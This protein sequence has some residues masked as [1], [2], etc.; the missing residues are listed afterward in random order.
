VIKRLLAL[1]GIAAGAYWFVKNRLGGQPDEFTFTEAPAPEAPP[2]VAPPA[3][4]LSSQTPAAEP[5][6][7]ESAPPSAPESGAPPPAA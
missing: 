2:S 3:E 4:G 7:A 5:R 6:S 1:A